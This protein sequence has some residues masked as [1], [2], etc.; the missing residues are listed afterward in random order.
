[1][2]KKA[3]KRLISA[4]TLFSFTVMFFSSQSKFYTRTLRYRNSFIY[5][6][7]CFFIRLSFFIFLYIFY[8][9]QLWN[10]HKFYSYYFSF[11]TGSSSAGVVKNKKC[12]DKIMMKNE[13]ISIKS[14]KTTVKLLKETGKIPLKMKE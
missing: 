6:S 8:R 3:F 5:F 4:F 10:I 13:K 2:K 12:G 7:L 11:P 9:T 1:M 14:E